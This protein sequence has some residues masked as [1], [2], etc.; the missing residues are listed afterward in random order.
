LI[1]KFVDF[2]KVV[3]SLE[4]KEKGFLSFWLLQLII[5]SL[6]GQTASQL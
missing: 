4:R 6:E 3:A 1:N 2:T 5:Q